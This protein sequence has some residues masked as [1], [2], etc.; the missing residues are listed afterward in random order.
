MTA[1]E[2]QALL[3][4]TRAPYLLQVLPEEIYAAT[5]LPSARNACVYEMTF[6]DQVRALKPD[7]NSS[8]VVY[9]A[10]DGS[11]DADTAADK[12]HAAGYTNVQVFEGGL[13][14]WQDAGL[15]LEGTGNLPAPPSPDGNYQ[16]DTDQ[17]LVRW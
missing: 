17:S 9:G 13:A 14:E 12:L 6:L 3:P 4:S 1:L 11:L 5:R 16:V 10:G 8:I 7:V 15:P 2:L